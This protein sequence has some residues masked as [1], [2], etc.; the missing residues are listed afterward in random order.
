[1]QWSHVKTFEFERVQLLLFFVCEKKKNY[2]AVVSRQNIRIRLLLFLLFDVNFF[3]FF[4]FLQDKFWCFYHFLWAFWLKRKCTFHGN[5]YINEKLNP[6]SNKKMQFLCKK[7]EENNNLTDYKRSYFLNFSLVLSAN[8]Y[9]LH[10]FT[11]KLS[12]NCTYII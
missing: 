8:M 2:N 5:I 7:E 6:F 11:G 4:L 1:M 9:Q 10:L 12:T 3:V